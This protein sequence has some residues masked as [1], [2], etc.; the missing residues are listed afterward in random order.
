MAYEALKAAFANEYSAKNKFNREAPERDLAMKGEQQRQLFES[1][2]QESNMK[3]IAENQRKFAAMEAANNLMLQLDATDINEFS[4]KL[5]KEHIAYLSKIESLGDPEEL[6]TARNRVKFD[7]M[8]S[9]NPELLKSI[10]TAYPELG[11]QVSGI[12]DKS[13]L[14]KTKE[15]I[16]TEYQS[17][18]KLS[19]QEH[20]QKIKEIEAAGK[21]ARK[22]IRLQIDN[23]SGADKKDI[24][25]SIA[26]D[27]ISALEKEASAGKFDGEE[28]AE[29]R[30]RLDSI[31]ERI[32]GYIK[33][34]NELETGT[35]SNLPEFK[36][37]Q[38]NSWPDHLR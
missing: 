1:Q 32:N 9:E 19:T 16:D 7:I 8:T 30:A 29:Y 4:D 12:T 25:L 36:N 34:V 24:R 27:A 33:F 5:N 17:K 21:E 31:L 28:D 11:Q 35:P 23:R 15:I 13:T 22:N 2:N 6:R 37:E 38:D 18:G 3:Q 26:R 20:K 10:S 14:G